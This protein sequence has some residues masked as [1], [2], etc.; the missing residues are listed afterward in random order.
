MRTTADSDSATSDSDVENSY[1]TDNEVETDFASESDFDNAD[2]TSSEVCDEYENLGMK[3]IIVDVAI[4]S[5]GSIQIENDKKSVEENLRQPRRFVLPEGTQVVTIKARR[6]YTTPGGILAFFSDGNVTDTSWSCID[7]SQFQ[8]FDECIYAC[9]SCSKSNWEK[10]SKTTLNTI[11][12]P[13]IA[14]SAQWIW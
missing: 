6:D 3:G 13:K 8:C 2:D 9:K 14:S 5:T 7:C 10:P 4:N 1:N 12:F 11:S